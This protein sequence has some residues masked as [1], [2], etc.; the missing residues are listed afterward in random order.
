MNESRRDRNKEEQ[1]ER[2]VQLKSSQNSIFTISEYQFSLHPCSSLSHARPEW[3]PLSASALYSFSQTVF[4]NCLMSCTCHPSKYQTS[5]TLPV[6]RLYKLPLTTVGSFCMALDI[7]RVPDIMKRL[8]FCHEKTKSSVCSTSSF[9][10]PFLAS[11]RSATGAGPHQLIHLQPASVHGRAGAWEHAEA[12][13][14]GHFH[15]H[16]PWCQRDQPRSGLCQV[17]ALVIPRIRAACGSRLVM[18]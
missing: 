12:L 9:L 1:N 17:Q 4:L 14:P 2:E 7:Q 5:L 15:P 13:Q 8:W 10:N 3:N 11:L 16:P 18:V 6:I